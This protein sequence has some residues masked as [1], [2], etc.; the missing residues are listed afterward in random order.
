MARRCYTESMKQPCEFFWIEDS[1]SA[2]YLLPCLVMALLELL[3]DSKAQDENKKWCLHFVNRLVTT[4]EMHEMEV[5][6]DDTYI[7]NHYYLSCN[8]VRAH[9]K[10][11]ILTIK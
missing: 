11:S 3:Q 8:K 4:F 1:D 5:I 6:T 2:H 9:Q 10:F 7:S